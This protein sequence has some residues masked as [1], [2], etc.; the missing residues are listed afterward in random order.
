M[1]LPPDQENI[2]LWLAALF[3]PT[4]DLDV[5][6]SEYI[7]LLTLW[8]SF[9][10]FWN[11][12]TAF[13]CR[14]VLQP[15]KVK[16]ES[17]LLLSVTIPPAQRELQTSTRRLFFPGL[18]GQQKASK[19]GQQKKQDLNAEKILDYIMCLLSTWMWN[20]SSVP[21]SPR[22]T[23]TVLASIYDLSSY[24]WTASQNQFHL[25]PFSLSHC[26]K[27]ESRLGVLWHFE[28]KNWVR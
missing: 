13:F 26:I 28:N 24:T 14:E 15:Q 10:S 6:P 16:S 17:H 19:R 3:Y 12:Q 22:S 27:S 8:S 11:K 23:V 20:K 18:L 4:T 5:K 25:S 7:L 9:G 1:N 2:C 21:R